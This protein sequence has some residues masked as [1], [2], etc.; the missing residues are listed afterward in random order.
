MKIVIVGG[1]KVGY[2]L[3]YELS[4]EGHDIVV[5]DNNPK[6]VEETVDS[7]DVM[8]MTGNGASYQVQVEAGVGKADLL[9][10]TTSSD[11]L[12]LL[13]CL[14]AKKV[15]ARH[16][17]AR[18]RNP[19]YSRQMGFFR[20]ELGLSMVVNP[21]LESADEI[22]RTLRFPSAIKMDKLAKGRVDLAEVNLGA[23]SPLDGVAISELHDRFDVKI[24]ICAV[25]R[26]TDV[27]IPNGSSVLKSG[28][29][30]HI[31]A[32]HPQLVTFFK[33]IGLY[34]ERVKEVIIIGGGK[35]AFYLSYKLLESG[36]RVRIVEQDAERCAQL[37]E[38]LPRAT[39]YHG[40]GTDP[41]LL[42]EL[43]LPRMDACV[44]LTGIDEENILISMYAQQQQVDKVITKINRDSFIQM[45]GTVGI[46]SVVS[47]RKL[48]TDRIIR[49]VRAMSDSEGSSMVTLYRL[50]N[51][52]MEA[53]EFVLTEQRFTGIPLRDMHLKDNLL[54]ACILRGNKLLFPA[55]G[56][57]LE[58][59]DIVVVVTADRTIRNF[60][61]IMA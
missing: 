31:A 3:T 10:A 42:Q 11:E 12:N 53:M 17:I 36:M 6:V 21:E 61:D 45:L 15:G 41:A 52:R 8:G 4:K 59:N 60:E 20:E 46:E 13:C 22:A 23:N 14:V 7:C 51:N 19:D 18:V 58:E 55:G 37:K 24:L 28:D 39:I 49:Y 26:G 34:R 33:A 9:I 56:D 25:Q 2:T 43:G 30:L 5:I 40:D 50:I 38:V 57:T 35:I 1:G 54:I 47:P 48:T 32:S 27:F 29:K 16:T 44:A